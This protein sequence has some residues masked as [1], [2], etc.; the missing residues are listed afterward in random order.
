[1][2][3]KD[4]FIVNSP[5]GYSVSCSKHIWDIH[6]QPGHPELKN[7]E[8]DVKETI[9]HPYKVF[10]SV[11]DPAR[12]VHYSPLTSIDG[13]KGHTAIITQPSKSYYGEH[14]IVT[15]FVDKKIRE[16]GKGGKL[17]YESSADSKNE[18]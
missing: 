2:S 7:H 13:H 14:T 8:N 3:D 16:E 5:L 9:E 15:A 11:S 4:L 18:L 1:M 12:H 10:Q 17:L 6:I